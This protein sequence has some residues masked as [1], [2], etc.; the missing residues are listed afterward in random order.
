MITF[1]RVFAELC[2]KRTLVRDSQPGGRPVDRCTSEDSSSYS[3]IASQSPEPTSCCRGCIA[4]KDVLGLIVLLRMRTL[5]SSATH[6]TMLPVT[7][8]SDAPEKIF[9]FRMIA[10]LRYAPV[11][12]A[13]VMP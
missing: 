11:W 3:T 13:H 7:S 8:F 4:P 12:Q 10:Q 2:S 9:C 6:L 1:S 5:G